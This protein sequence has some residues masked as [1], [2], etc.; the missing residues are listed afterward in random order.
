MELLFTE[1][2]AEFVLNVIES[3]ELVLES[4]HIAY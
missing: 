3:H 2:N 4:A 1:S